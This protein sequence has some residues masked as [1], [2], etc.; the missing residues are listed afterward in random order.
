M[1]NAEKKM[2]ECLNFIV[3]TFRTLHSYNPQRDTRYAQLE[4]WTQ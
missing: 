1:R 4:L 3:S 2:I